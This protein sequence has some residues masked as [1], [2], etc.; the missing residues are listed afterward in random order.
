MFQNLISEACVVTDF[1]FRQLHAKENKIIY[2]RTIFQIKFGYHPK[3][4]LR[5]FLLD[6]Y[7]AHFFCPSLDISLVRRWLNVETLHVHS[8]MLDKDALCNI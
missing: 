7:D 6:F 2:F 4:Q 5:W 3:R 8:G 1:I